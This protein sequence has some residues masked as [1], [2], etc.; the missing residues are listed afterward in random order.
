MPGPGPALHV[1]AVVMCPHAAPATVVTTNTRVLVSGSPVSVVTDVHPVAGCPFQVP[2]GTG[3]KPQPCVQVRW[4]APATRVTVMG[5]PVLAAT[6]NGLCTSAEQI[7]QGAPIVTTVQ[8]RVV[9][10]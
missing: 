5:Q 9:V 2:I 8:P 10:T 1:G 4:V 7:V 6:S 3:T